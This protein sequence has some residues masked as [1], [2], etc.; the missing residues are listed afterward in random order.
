MSETTCA[1]PLRRDD[2]RRQVSELRRRQRE[3]D[4]R[5]V[6]VLVS[7]TAAV[8]RYR[9]IAELKRRGRL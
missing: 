3:L 2:L 6:K 5:V 1:K 7:S 4:A 8:E 9:A